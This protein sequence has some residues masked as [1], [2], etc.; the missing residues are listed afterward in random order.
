[1]HAAVNK[2]KRAYFVVAPRR[3]KK[4]CVTSNRPP[5]ALCA[6]IMLSA[7]LLYYMYVLGIWDMAKTAL[8]SFDAADNTQGRVRERERERKEGELSL[9]HSSFV[10][11]RQS[12]CLFAH[13]VTQKEDTDAAR[14]AIR[15]NNRL[16][17]FTYIRN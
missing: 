10:A 8:Q 4:K 12:F 9:R 15:I 16:G 11:K 14:G 3:E 1:M 2:I 5:Q 13:L 17:R 7:L 6:Y